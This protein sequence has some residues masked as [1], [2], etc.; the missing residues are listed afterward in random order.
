MKCFHQGSHYGLEEET[1]PRHEVDEKY[2]ESWKS[3]E[4]VEVNETEEHVTLHISVNTQNFE[5]DNET[6]KTYS[7]YR[8]SK[9]SS[10]GNLNQMEAKENN[11]DL[12]N[13]DEDPKMISEEISPSP[14]LSHYQSQFASTLAMFDTQPRV[15]Y[16][17]VC[18][19]RGV[20]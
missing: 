10:K 2:E 3:K 16:I 19:L 15:G 9:E 13:K 18:G 20:R 12:I 6:F 5:R 1:R 14:N 17:P 11:E 8:D 4:T 7:K